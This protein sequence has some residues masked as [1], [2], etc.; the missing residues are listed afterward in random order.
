MFLAK[1]Y[2]SSGSLLD[3]LTKHSGEHEYRIKYGLGVFKKCAKAV[4]SLN[5]Q[6]CV[7]NDLCP[8]NFVKIGKEW[9]IA[10]FGLAS[11][12]GKQIACNVA[13][14][15]WGTPIYMSPEAFDV[16]SFDE[17]DV[18]S[19]VYSMSVIL[20][21]ML[22]PDTSPPFYAE[23]SDQLRHLHCHMRAD[24]LSCVDEYLAETTAKG[25]SKDLAERYESIEQMLYE[26]EIR[27]KKR[28]PKQ[29]DEEYFELGQSEHKRGNYSKAEISLKKVA[30]DCEGYGTAFSLLEDIKMRYS[31]V[32][33][34][35][36]DILRLMENKHD[37]T[38]ARD[39]YCQSNA[40]YP[41]H[42]ALR[43]VKAKLNANCKKANLLFESFSCSLD[44]GDIR[45]A[46][47]CFKKLAAIDSDSKQTSKARRFI[48]KIK[49]AL[50]EMISRLNIAEKNRDYSQS[51]LIRDEYSQ[52]I[53]SLAS[54]KNVKQLAQN[55][56]L[57]P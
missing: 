11:S 10:D 45:D 22:S 28:S 23:S 40:I 15:M 1:E 27:G 33:E 36:P 31:Q 42:P 16:D 24:R 34:L 51:L 30:T 57:L 46:E 35:I 44:V 52:L 3:W 43:T 9:K 53:N 56:K 55:I 20:Y 5:E 39:L 4:S 47:R 21:Q 48:D 29:T 38:G 14:G 26:I 13:P 6:G 49:D 25:L 37:L 19:D 54:G 17:L 50:D 8:A 2:S 12:I 18:R 7:C 32:G 41:S